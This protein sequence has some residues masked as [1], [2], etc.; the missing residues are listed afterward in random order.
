MGIK[1]IIENTITFSPSFDNL[2]IFA[3]EYT[4]DINIGYYVIKRVWVQ[5]LKSLDIHYLKN[6]D[7][8]FQYLAS[9]KLMI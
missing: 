3:I 9:Y 7:F 5:I 1:D 2:K 4:N 8:G 6:F